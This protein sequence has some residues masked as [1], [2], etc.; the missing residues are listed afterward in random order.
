Q[1]DDFLFFLERLHSHFALD[2]VDHFLAVT[3]NRA[4]LDE[5]DRHATPN[6]VTRGAIHQF[7]TMPIQTDIHLR[8]TIFIETGLRIGHLITR[9]DQ[10]ALQQ[11]RRTPFL[12]KLERLGGSARRI[13]L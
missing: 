13:Q 5:D 4:L 2:A 11:Y 12:T 8:T 6:V 10:A 7:A 1:A 9:D 3:S